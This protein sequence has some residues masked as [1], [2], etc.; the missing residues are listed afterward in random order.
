M[1]REVW[2]SRHTPFWKAVKKRRRNKF[3]SAQAPRSLP[4]L[5]SGSQIGEHPVEEQ[6]FHWLVGYSQ[7]MGIHFQNWMAMMAAIIMLEI[8]Y[9]WIRKL[10]GYWSWEAPTRRVH[11]RLPFALACTR[12]IFLRTAG[13]YG[14][15]ITFLFRC[16][17]IPMQISDTYRPQ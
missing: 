2:T 4:G 15:P 14:F 10:F 5:R 6:A 11:G 17:R 9:V 12:H 16:S 8:V 13:L 3:A 1:A 7:V